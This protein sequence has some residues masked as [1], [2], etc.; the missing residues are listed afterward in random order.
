MKQLQSV[1]VDVKTRNGLFEDVVA[2]FVTECRGIVEDRVKKA[3]S[4][5]S[6]EVLAEQL[7]QGRIDPRNIQWALLDM[8]KLQA[9]LAELS[10]ELSSLTAGVFHRPVL[11]QVTASEDGL[12]PQDLAGIIGEELDRNR[13]TL[14]LNKTMMEACSLVWSRAV[15]DCAWPVRR[16]N[17]GKLLWCLAGVTPA[18]EEKRCLQGLTR[19][20]EGVRVSMQKR[21]FR[22]ISL[23]VATQV[24][25]LYDSVSPEKTTAFM[26]PEIF[27]A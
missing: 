4:A 7:W 11:L 27:L 20:V 13:G 18:D 1:P 19:S 6:G 8:E 3:F 26:N 2:S 22:A 17:P 23:Q 25:S 15:S 16:M 24:W 9:F 10:A 5:V 14:F 12:W 21:L